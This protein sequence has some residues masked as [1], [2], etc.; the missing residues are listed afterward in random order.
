MLLEPD[1]AVKLGNSELIEGE[2]YEDK[3]LVKPCCKT[4]T[5]KF[6]FPKIP[7]KALPAIWLLDIHADDPLR[8]F[9]KNNEMLESV[10]PKFLPKKKADRNPVEGTLDGDAAEMTGCWKLIA[11]DKEAKLFLNETNKLKYFPTPAGNFANVE[12]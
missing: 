1:D 3:V 11:N 12:L 10:F 6:T 2:S 8:V 4:E 5:T 9:P 7:W